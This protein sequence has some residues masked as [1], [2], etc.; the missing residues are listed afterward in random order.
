MIDDLFYQLQGA[1]VFPKINLRYGYH[2][3][4]IKNDDIPNISFRTKYGHYEFQIMSFGLTN[5]LGKF[6]GSRELG[7]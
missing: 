3:L 2:E 4:Q 7:I 1:K 6:Y 5:T